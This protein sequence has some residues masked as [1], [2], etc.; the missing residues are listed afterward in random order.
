M[1]RKIKKRTIW[2]LISAM[3][4]SFVS[5]GLGLYSE[6]HAYEPVRLTS[7]KDIPGV[8]ADDIDA[9][10]ALR[11]QYGSFVYGVLPS[12]VAFY[13]KDGNIRGFSALFCEWLS[14]LFDIP[15]L[16]EFVEWGE[17]LA[18]LANFEV[19]FTGA[20]TATEERLKHILR[21]APLPRQ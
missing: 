10:E 2:L 11:E 7:Y 1:E 5:S 4:L 8:T 6:V 9:I 12:T 15:F 16:P 17:F 20:M 18:K 14:E 3:I 13:D 19:D 21:P